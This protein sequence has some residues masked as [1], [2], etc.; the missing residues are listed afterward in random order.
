MDLDIQALAQA[1]RDL[2]PAPANPAPDGAVSP[3]ALKQPAFWTSDPEE[4]F[5]QV[6]A[7]FQTKN[8]PSTADQTRFYYVIGALDPTA[9][10]EVRS[11]ILNPPA[12]GD[13]GRYCGDPERVSPIKSAVDSFLS[14]HFSSLSHF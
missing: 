4:W 14:T 3:V 10:K 1:I 13:R 5:T 6:E 7:Q 11:I 12:A 9:A 8:P 2:A